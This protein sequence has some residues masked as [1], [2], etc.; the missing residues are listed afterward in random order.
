MPSK[1]EK[2]RIEELESQVKE[3]SGLVDILIESQ[4]Y[5]A[6]QLPA[7]PRATDSNQLELHT[8]LAPHTIVEG[9]K[10]GLARI[11]GVQKGEDIETRIGNTW[12]PRVAVLLFMTVLV[13]GMRDDTVHPLYKICIG[14]S[15][16]VVLSV[17]GIWRRQS[18]SLFTKA[19]MGIGV[20]T[21]YF[22]TYSLYYLPEI[23]LIESMQW[24]VPATAITLLLIGGLLWVSNSQFAS[25]MIL[26]FVH[27]TIVQFFSYEAAS[28]DIVYPMVS[29][30]IM[31]LITS[32]LQFRGGWKWSSWL[33]LISIY[34]GYIYYFCLPGPYLSATVNGSPLDE[35]SYHFLYTVFLTLI[36]ILLAMATMACARKHTASG[37]GMILFTFANIIGY[38]YANQ[39]A[40][41]HAPEY[42]QLAFALMSISCAVFA[43]LARPYFSRNNVIMQALLSQAVLW[44]AL[45]LD[46]ALS[47]EWSLI[48]YGILCLVLAIIY[49][50]LP[51]TVII[52]LQ[53]MIMIVIFVGAINILNVSGNTSMLNFVLPTRWIFSIGLVS[54]FTFIAW[55]YDNRVA[56]YPTKLSHSEGKWILSSR[57]F[58]WSPSVVAILNTTMGAF[59]LSALTIYDLGS[60]P[61]LPFIL[62]GEG[63]AF[64][65]MGV[66]LRTPQ[67]KLSSVLLLISSHVTFHFFLYMELPGFTTQAFF[68]QATICLA[69]ISYLG[70]YFWERYI[71]QIEEGTIWEHDLLSAIPFVAT[72]LIL[73]SLAEYLLN[74][75]LGSLAQT[76][77]GFLLMATGMLNCLIGLRIAALTALGLGA[78]SFYIRSLNI[79]VPNTHYD[80]Y[81]LIVMGVVLSLAASERILH[82]WERRTEATSKVTPGFHTI[83]VLVSVTF[84]TL[85]LWHGSS[86][87]QLSLYLMTWSL[88]VLTFGAVFRSAYYRIAALL[89]IF[90]VFVRLYMY[91]LST[92][93]P[94][95]K[96]AVFAVF[97]GIIFLIS[98][99]YS[100]RRAK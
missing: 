80:Y 99:G 6:K 47:L 79:L 76:A 8:S 43:F 81:F 69:L 36:Y 71:H 49:K 56:P 27:Y 33:A 20:S 60:N 95:L 4:D 48:S 57:R 61:L 58:Q 42:A 12:L 22:A 78:V 53:F 94:L 21:V 45:Y 63:L 51:L 44:L 41:Q 35:T 34:G 32:L 3:L 62:A 74:S 38:L 31:A 7:P 67:M 55:Y 93:A 87:E 75:P 100:R 90:S 37:R 26:L 52:A 19:M 97:T 17:Y 18:P 46:F 73:T 70:S 77:L 86:E 40:I 9:V 13:L 72:T 5:N 89:L 68:I 11:L 65:L 82:H 14:Y 66:V 59:I 1:K 28:K 85:G 24:A 92:L 83:L 25:I 64:A 88:G 50:R 84:G 54:I 15:I 2:A 29:W 39:E 23:Q 98:W 10:G 96:I 91:D 16:G 30:G